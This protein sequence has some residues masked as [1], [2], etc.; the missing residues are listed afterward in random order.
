MRLFANTGLPGSAL[1]GGFAGLYT[2]DVNVYDGSSF[3]RV[4]ASARRH[5]SLCAPSVGPGFDARRATGTRGGEP[6]RNGATY[7]RMWRAAVEPGPT[8]SRSRATTSGTRARRSSPRRRSGPAYASYDGAYG[9][10][11]KAAQTAYLDSTARWASRYRAAL[12]R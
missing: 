9:L 10:V 11:G 8:S 7:D 5:R 1:A 4:C 3:P 6:R 12:G 2:Y